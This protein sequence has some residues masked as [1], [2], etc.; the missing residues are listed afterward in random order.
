MAGGNP[1]IF[2]F[3]SLTN[4]PMPPQ[5]IL[6][7]LFFLQGLL[8]KFNKLRIFFRK[9]HLFMMFGLVPNILANLIY[10]RF[11]HGKGRC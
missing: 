1:S 10:I 7:A 4:Q 8:V 2:T 9:A 6:L 5:V 3:S 11:G